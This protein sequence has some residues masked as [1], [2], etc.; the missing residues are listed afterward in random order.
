MATKPPVIHYQIIHWSENAPRSPSDASNVRGG[1]GLQLGLTND[2]TGFLPAWQGEKLST[3][4]AWELETYYPIW[5]FGRWFM[6]LFYPHSILPE[7]IAL[8]S[9]YSEIFRN[10]MEMVLACGCHT[11]QVWCNIMQR[12]HLL[13]KVGTVTHSHRLQVELLIPWQLIWPS[14]SHAWTQG[15]NFRRIKNG[16]ANLGTICWVHVWRFML[17][18]QDN[19]KWFQVPYDW[20]T[21]IVFW[22]SFAGTPCNL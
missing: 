8:S 7:N 6:A 1:A 10:W 11:A 20:L 15:T 21:Q 14:L 9:G 12:C 17:L 18:Q 5:W 16:M 2:F 3:T 13:S 22:F 4:H 19:Y